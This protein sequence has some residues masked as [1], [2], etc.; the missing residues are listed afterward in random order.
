MEQTTL[1]PAANRRAMLY[2]NAP[3]YF[4]LAVVV[5]WVGFSQSYFARLRE[6]DVYHHL[7]G[8]FVGT[9]TV[10]LIV[11]PILYRQKKIQLHRRLGWAGTIMLVPGILL[12]GAK[13]MQM[14]IQGQATYPPGTVYQLSFIDATSLILFPLFLGLSLRYGRRLPLHARYMACTMLV[15]LPPAIGRLLFFIPWFDS[16]NKA[17]NGS[18]VVVDC[19]LLILIADDKRNHGRIWQSY[20]LALLLFGLL[21][22]AMNYAGSWQWWHV[23]MDRFAGL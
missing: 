2:P 15:V 14:M 10:L 5:T 23:L 11:Q 17:L 18:F 6:T 9:W 22:I 20:P 12:G 16:F 13:M 8:A 19:I 4:A 21:H 1:S 3:W 7:H